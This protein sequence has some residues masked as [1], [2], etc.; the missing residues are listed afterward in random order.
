[1]FRGPQAQGQIEGHGFKISI[2]VPLL[3]RINAVCTQWMFLP[4]YILKKIHSLTNLPLFTHSVAMSLSFT[5]CKSI[6]PLNRSS[7]LL[8][9][10]GQF[11]PHGCPSTTHL[12]HESVGG[13]DLELFLLHPSKVA[14]GKEPRV[15]VAVLVVGYP[16][17]EAHLEG[18]IARE[19][20]GG[21]TLGELFADDLAEVL[22][23]V[24]GKWKG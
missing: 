10:V 21:L 9:A 24:T 6:D 2:V 5:A 15:R 8:E 19:G 18:L 22:A 14:L 13:D 11:L 3:A 7:E 1:M 16:L 12:L 23:E 20:R 4:N 17:P